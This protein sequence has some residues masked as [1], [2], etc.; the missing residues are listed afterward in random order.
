[1]RKS[2]NEYIKML[3]PRIFWDLNIDKLD[4]NHD[5]QIIIERIAVHGTENDERIMNKLYRIE[6]I[7]K[8]LVNSS[9]LSEKVIRYYAFALKIKE[10][11]F[12]CFSKTHVQMS[13]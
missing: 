12:K 5:K 9:N 13:C 4:Y 11:D 2:K 1:M 7:E 8:C 3:H 10:E 6:T